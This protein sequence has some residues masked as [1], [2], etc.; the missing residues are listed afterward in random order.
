[1]ASARE[2]THKR[3]LMNTKTVYNNQLNRLLRK[4]IKQN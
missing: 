4:N 1:M 3:K 2:H